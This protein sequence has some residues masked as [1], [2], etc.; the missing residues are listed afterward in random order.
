M[1]DLVETVIS[2]VMRQDSAYKASSSAPSR[3]RMPAPAHQVHHLNPAPGMSGRTPK[4]NDPLWQASRQ[5][6]ALFV[7]QMLASMRKT[8]PDSGLLKKGFAEGVQT[9]MLDQAV[10]DSIG[11]Q[12]RMG[13]ASSLY[14]QLSNHYPA[15]A[16]TQNGDKQF[17]TAMQPGQGAKQDHGI[18]QGEQHGTH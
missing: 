17:I 13:I 5:F 10:A 18:A 4:A 8:I 12:G 6:E 7:E 1:R 14:R 9:S 15:Q 16:G 2:Q 3:P 11:K